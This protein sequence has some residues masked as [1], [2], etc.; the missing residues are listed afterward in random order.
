MRTTQRLTGVQQ[1]GF[2]T[3]TTARVAWALPL[4]IISQSCASHANIF[5][6]RLYISK[7]KVQEY[8]EIYRA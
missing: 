8:L 1:V 6:S 4:R 3:F 5:V 7:L 2:S